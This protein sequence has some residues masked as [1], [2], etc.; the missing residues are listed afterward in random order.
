MSKRK[1][2]EEFVSELK[3][4]NKNFYNIE[5]LSEYKGIKNRIKCKCKICDHEWQPTADSL[6]MGTGCPM[7]RNKKLIKSRSKSLNDFLN[8]LHTIRDDI[9]YV[10]GYKNTKTKATFKCKKHNILFTT[11]PE[12][13]L[14]GVGCDLCRKEKPQYNKLTKEQINKTIIHLK[15]EMIGEYVNSKTATKFRCKLC[16]K[17]FVSTYDLIRYWR[18]C[19]C[20]E[21]KEKNRPKRKDNVINNRISK[22]HSKKSE[23]VKILSYDEECERILCQCLLCKDTYETCYDSIVQGCMHKKCASIIGQSNIRLSNEEIIKR[24]QSFGNN[25]NIDFSNYF[26]SDSLLQCECNVCH[27]KWKAKQKN[28]I[29]GRGCPVCAKKR[30]DKS[31]YKSLDEYYELL[32]DMNLRVIS[33][34]VNATTPVKLK[35]NKCG[36]EFE[37]TMSYISNTSIG[38]KNCT[39]EKNRIIKLNAFI[40]DLYNKNSTIKLV[41]DFVDMSTTTT[42][43]CTNCNHK[44]ERTPHDILRYDNCPK[45]TTNSRLEYHIKLFLDKYKINY[46]LHHSFDGLY[47]VNGGLLSYDF[48]LPEYNVLIE[49]QG[50]Q[51]IEPIAHFGGEEQF[52]IQVEHD[53]R[54]REYAKT[55]N[56]KLLEIFYNDINNIS[57]ILCKQ[58]NIDIKKAS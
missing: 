13:I 12:S 7:C 38:C 29:R 27:N 48:Y 20:E 6:M 37:S 30:R 56:I 19:G 42:F 43:L 45:C 47:G 16:D 10:S 57:S 11:T 50:K 41:G 58:F 28:L 49:A 8:E 40:E 34:Y 23:Y 52:I 26:S 36:E 39:Q 31:K 21:C 18:I 1:T 17:E 46:E 15:I 51:H 3:L 33:D 44:F 35:C 9:E 32:N 22:L 53:E 55:K 4:K 25:I 2:H 54:K 24:V 14:K 5:F